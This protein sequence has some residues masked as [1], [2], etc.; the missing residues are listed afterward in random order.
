MTV[1]QFN[2]IVFE[3]TRKYVATC[4]NLN[5]QIQTSQT[6]DQPCSDTSPLM[7]GVLCNAAKAEKVVEG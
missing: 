1:L 2:Q 4:M 7:V 3:Q 6:G 5:Y